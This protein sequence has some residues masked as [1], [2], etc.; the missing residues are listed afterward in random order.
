MPG[1]PVAGC[2]LMPGVPCCRSG[3][4]CCRACP[5]ARRALLPGVPCCRACPVAGRALLPAGRALLPAGCALLLTGCALLPDVPCCQVCYRYSC[6]QS[7]GTALA[8]LRE[9]SRRRGLG[10]AASVSVC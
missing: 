3:V 1:E 9:G 10:L 8:A 2:A 7:S 5:V 6:L 4:P